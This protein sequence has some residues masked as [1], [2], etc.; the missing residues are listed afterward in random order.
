MAQGSE[1]EASTRAVRRVLL[2]TLVLN[3]AVAAA[4]VVYGTLASSLSIRAD[5]F[6]SAADALNNVVALVAVS[7]AARPPDHDHPYGHKKHEVVAA[8]VIGA[9]L[10]LIAVDV[11]RDAVARLTGEAALPELDNTAWI[12]LG[13]TWIVN[14]FVATWEA[15]EA[16]RHH[17]PALSSDAQHTRAD[18]LVTLAVAAAVLF[19]RMGYPL[20][21]AVAA[22][23]VAG[24]VAWAGI[25]VLRENFSYLSDT[26]L[27][28]VDKVVALARSVPGVKHAH[29][30][31]SRGVPGHA[32]VDLHI[33]LAKDLT[34]EEAHAITHRAMDAI[35]AGI[36]GVADVTIHTEPDGHE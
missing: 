28:D 16:K 23:G 34:L 14:L 21:D 20:A 35:R 2:V 5:G 26:A 3:L 24:F 13:A 6:H 17:S 19:T 4:K 10:L 33:H 8:A 27:V 9:S 12:V 30:V 1:S 7:L 11:V 32:F 15:R 31:R 25:G 18:V 36:E 29:K 22:L